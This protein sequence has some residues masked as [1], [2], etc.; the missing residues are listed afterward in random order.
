MASMNKL[1]IRGVRSF[2]PDDEEQV[3]VFGFPLT[4][5]VGANGCGKTTII[6]SLKYAVTGGFPPGVKNGQAFVHDPKSA[7]QSNVKASIKLRFTNRAG[8]S[9][10]VIRSMEVTQKKTTLSFK[11]LDGILRTTHPETGERISMSH[12]CTELDRQ[13]PTMLGVSKAILEHVVFCHQEESSWPLMEGA[14]LKKRF[15]EIFDSTR[16]AKALKAITECKKEHAASAKELQIDLASL[17]AHKQTASQFRADMETTTEKLSEVE[18]LMQECTKGMAAQDV[19]IAKYRKVLQQVEELREKIQIKEA[20]LDR[21]TG[22]LESRRQMLEQD[23]TEKHGLQELQKMLR[24]FEHQQQESDAV[25][26]QK[27]QEYQD[28]KAAMSQLAQQKSQLLQDQSRLQTLQ[29]QHHQHVEQQNTKIAQ[30]CSTHNIDFDG[31]HYSAPPGDH[32]GS[33]GTSSVM[34]GASTAMSAFTGLSQAIIMG[35]QTTTATNATGFRVAATQDTT[36]VRDYSEDEV[37]YFVSNLEQTLVQNQRSL[38]NLKQGHQTT[39]DKVLSD[40]GDLQAKQ[41]S[42]ENDIHR[43][44]GERKKVELEIGSIRAQQQYSRVRK[45]DV[46]DAKANAERLVKER[47]DLSNDS[48][49]TSIP[50]DIKSLDSD[51]VKLKQQID[52]ESDIVTSLRKNAQ[53]QTSITTLEREMESD[54]ERLEDVLR[55]NSFLFQKFGLAASSTNLTSLENLAQQAHNKKETLLEELRQTSMHVSDKQR[56]VTE[57]RTILGQSQKSVKDAQRRMQL[58]QSNPNG[59]YAQIQTVLQEV[60]QYESQQQ[61]G[62]P[63]GNSVPTTPNTMDPKVLQTNLNAALQELNAD[64]NDNETAVI[65]TIKKLKKMVSRS[66]MYRSKSVCVMLPV[67][68]TEAMAFIR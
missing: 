34:G 52:E 21:E 58:L 57:Q 44:R 59:G 1:A 38:A 63:T 9:M 41:S 28:V 31:E 2:S 18:E 66:C 25:L 24:G 68:P 53:E 62:S 7:G 3:I 8:N 51:I 55:D 60:R 67:V 19:T 26:Q 46:D 11:A 50:N 5:I 13:I 43:I 37:A 32:D 15:D 14:V 33:D 35:T 61:S 6:E 65:Q 22:I 36:A 29:S 42:I 48:K 4:I 39:Q 64:G 47:D 30:V 27:V 17:Q 45:N 40:L 20:A 54:M 23:L 56:R 12:K 10:V 49:L 16:Y